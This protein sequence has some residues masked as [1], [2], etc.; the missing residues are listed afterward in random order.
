[1]FQFSSDWFGM[2]EKGRSAR[3]IHDVR[4]DFIYQSNLHSITVVAMGS[5]NLQQNIIK[6]LEID[7]FHGEEQEAGVITKIN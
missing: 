2:K 7:G 3:G 6:M 1:M 5:Q 4:Y